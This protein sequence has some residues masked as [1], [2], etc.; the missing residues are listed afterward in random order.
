MQKKFWS[1]RISETNN[2]RVK[3]NSKKKQNMA[4]EYDEVSH[5]FEM[6]NDISKKLEY[7]IFFTEM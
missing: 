1:S 3:K 6:L 5:V 7:E 2:A 4:V